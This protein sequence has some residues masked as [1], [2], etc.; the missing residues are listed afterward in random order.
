VTLPLWQPG[1]P[2]ES[3]R[4]LPGRYPLKSVIACERQSWTLLSWQ[5]GARLDSETGELTCEGLQE[6]TKRPFLCGSWKCRRCALWRGAVDWARCRAAVESRPW[7]L[8]CVLTFD[9]SSWRERWDAYQEAGRLWNNHLREA[10]RSR[11]RRAPVAYLQTWEAHKSRWPHVNMILSGDELR[12][13]VERSGPLKTREVVGA[14][15][16]VRRATWPPAW[17]RWFRGAAERAGFGRI[18]WVEIIDHA[19][20]D[21][22]AGYLCKLARELTGAPGGSKGEQSPTDAPPGFRRI[23]ASRGLLPPGPETGAEGW[24][25]AL[26]TYDSHL[27]QQPRRRTRERQPRMPATW[28]E[29]M[30]AFDARAKRAVADW[31]GGRLPVGERAAE[32]E[33]EPQPEI[34]SSWEGL[35]WDEPAAPW[36]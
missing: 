9:P 33:L 16:S 22:M 1:D 36:G 32:L 7:W 24:T 26:V 19:N 4:D 5:E 21:A 25:G 29:A 23:R 8:Y 28:L 17:R 18:A 27:P 14:G 34:R 35:L 10:L 3:W 30:S 31:L 11:L 12:A 13:D 15:G 20:P 2:L 6:P